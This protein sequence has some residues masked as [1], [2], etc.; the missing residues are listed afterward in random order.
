MKRFGFGGN[1]KK[2]K[3]TLNIVKAIGGALCVLLLL[4]LVM[5]NFTLYW[6]MLF[7]GNDAM[8]R[9]QQGS[10]WY[11]DWASGNEYSPGNP[12]GSSGPSGG[13]NYGNTGMLGKAELEAM[14]PEE[15]VAAVTKTLTDE[16]IRDPET[17][18]RVFIY[19][20]D[21][22]G[23]V[24]NAIIGAMSYVKAEGAGMGTFTYES[25]LLC[26]GPDGNK[27]SR[28]LGNQDWLDWLD[29]PGFKWAES[30]YA[31]RRAAGEK[32][33]YAAI[34]I[35]SVQS[36][37]VWSGPGSKTTANATQMIQTATTKG[38]YWQDPGFQMPNLMSR[39]FVSSEPF[40]KSAWDVDHCPGVDPTTDN[41]VTAFE[42]SKRVLCGVGYPGWKSS[43][44][45]DTNKHVVSHA[46]GIDECTKLYDQYSKKDPWF[47]TEMPNGTLDWRDP[48]HG[49]Y[50]D[51]STPMG[52]QIAR[53]GVLFAGTERVT[54]GKILFDA[55]GL[56]SSNL[57]DPR[58]KYYK[59]AQTAST[60]GDSTYYASC[61]YAT[62][63]AVLMAGA[64]DTIPRGAAPDVKNYLD[65]SSKWKKIGK[66]EDVQPQPGDVLADGGHVALYVGT[67]VAGERWPGTTTKIYQAS[68]GE[69]FPD[70]AVY[71]NKG[72]TVYRCIQPDNSSKYWNKFIT[73]ASDTLAVLPRTYSI[74]TEAQQQPL[75]SDTTQQA[76]TSIGTEIDTTGWVYPLPAEWKHVSSRLGTRNDPV[77]KGTTENHKGNDIPATDGTP[78]YSAVDGVVGK[79]ATSD[80]RGKYVRIDSPD[81]G[82]SIIYQHMSANYDFIVSVGQ[83]VTAGQQIGYVGTT[84]KSTGNHLHFE[85]CNYPYD[86]TN[87]TFYDI[88]AFYP[89][90][91]LTF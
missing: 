31:S 56:A 19:L 68:Y 45:S 87:G 32:L 22:H 23:F 46:A 11:G 76:E 10:E 61:D 58:L 82:V 71:S 34:G 47:Y 74:P 64:D 26:P 43:E 70:M 65:N 67:N 75:P 49:P 50:Y 20:M 4:F 37:D 12:S 86:W 69:H 89:N 60:G 73:A 52:L 54:E 51:N 14:T 21:R 53:M 66:Y 35:G 79:V 5:D 90:I 84:G 25:Y 81:A 85:I 9:R 88:E 1:K 83:K 27:S 44:F 6:F 40:G 39:Y 36:S 18:W 72:M 33:S 59:E 77:Y 17:A 24:P 78:I 13:S 16:Q 29:G 55:W 63:L 38:L 42:W 2:N 28:H 41:N 48:F 8:E 7:N 3:K 62:T 91:G 30:N 15:A 80:G 57:N